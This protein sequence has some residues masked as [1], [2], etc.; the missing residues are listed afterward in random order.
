[1]HSL[2]LP[3]RVVSTGQQ[4]LAKLDNASLPTQAETNASSTAHSAIR[5][6][7][8][9]LPTSFTAFDLG[10]AG[11][12]SAWNV[13]Y[14]PSTASDVLQ[15]T[16]SLLRDWVRSLTTLMVQKTH[17]SVGGKSG[18]ASKRQSRKKKRRKLLHE[19]DGF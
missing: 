1:M 17:P 6:V 4:V 16:A 13:Q 10:R 3:Q 14:A 9:L 5:R 18:Q 7:R 11:N 19:F 12:G 2:R 8:S 15:P